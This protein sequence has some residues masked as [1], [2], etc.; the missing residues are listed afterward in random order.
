[1]ARFEWRP[2]NILVAEIEYQKQAVFKNYFMA[3]LPDLIFQSWLL[4]KK[5]RNM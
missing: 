3:R 5:D 4:N 2:I 1:M